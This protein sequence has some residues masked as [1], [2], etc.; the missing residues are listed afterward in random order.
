LA[1]AKA[2]R[3]GGTATVVLRLVN[4]ITV[5]VGG[6]YSTDYYDHSAPCVTLA[7]QPAYLNQEEPHISSGV[8]RTAIYPPT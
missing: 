3:S 8:A 6:H 5:S 1:L 4:G 7:K 2:T